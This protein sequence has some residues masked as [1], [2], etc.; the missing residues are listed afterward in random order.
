MAVCVV[1]MA[2]G[3][4]LG[5]GWAADRLVLRARLRAARRD[6]VT[7]LC[8]RQL[9]ERQAAK[10]TRPGGMVLL[11]DIDAF[12]AVNDAWG[13]LAGDALLAATGQ[14]LAAWA[15]AR[16]GAAARIGGD[17][18]A[19]A[20]TC[21]AGAAPAALDSLADRLAGPA[22]VPGGML[23]P[24]RVPVGACVLPAGSGRGGL[25]GAMAGADAAMYQAKREGARWR[26]T[27]Q[28]PAAPRRS[29]E[30]RIRTHGP[31]ESVVEPGPDRWVRQE[32]GA[33]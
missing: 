3:L 32:T 7:G 15:S 33:R 28:A 6:P 11:A 19:A 9:W 29:L 2:A 16:R 8:T 27:T 21:P 12:K 1:D 25:R 17:E 23:I 13:H 31:G 26:L 5:G 10:L 22:Q 20:I 24:V 14:R 18:F 30:H 4:A